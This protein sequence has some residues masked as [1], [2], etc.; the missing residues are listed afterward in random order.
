[1]LLSILTADSNLPDTIALQGALMERFFANAGQQ[2]LE[3]IRG[4][5]DG[6]HEFCS[7]TGVVCRNGVVRTL[8]FEGRDP[9]NLGLYF[10]PA[11]TQEIQIIKCCQRYRLNTRALPRELLIVNLR[12][13]SLSGPIDLTVLPQRLQVANFASNRLTGP[14]ALVRLPRTLEYLYLGGN[15]IVQH[16]IWYDHLPKGLSKVSLNIIADSNRIRQVRAVDSR[17]RLK[18]GKVFSSAGKRIVVDGYPPNR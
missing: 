13:N 3:I 7:W 1:M 14:I 6:T 2:F 9:G 4:E 12:R 18:N 16:T 10:L 8:H 15:R 17:R 11:T 5:H